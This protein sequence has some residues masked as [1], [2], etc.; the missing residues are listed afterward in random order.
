MALL[1]S[2]KISYKR[3]FF[4][5]Q[6][7]F[8]I[9]NESGNTTI[10]RL[11]GSLMFNHICYVYSRFALTRIMNSTTNMQIFKVKFKFASMGHLCS[12]KINMHLC[13]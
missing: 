11:L 8:K 4:S 7:E 10:K 3:G 5:P 2:L 12:S 9:G 1:I 6:Y 13:V